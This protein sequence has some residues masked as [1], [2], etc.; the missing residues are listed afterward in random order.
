VAHLDGEQSHAPD[1]GESAL[2]AALTMASRG[3]DE[4]GRAAPGRLAVLYD[5]SCEMCV[6]SIGAIARFDNSNAIDA[7]DLF[8]SKA[9]ERFPDLRRE[10]LVRALHV[11]DDH[12][13]VFRGA[14]ALN[15]ILRHQR[16]PKGWLAYAWFI[17]GFA[18]LA[19]RQYKKI[20]ANRHDR[21]THG[22]LRSA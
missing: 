9:A 6:A 14:R 11:V 15:E 12:G 8:D 1:D 7:L 5:G 13:R 20:A 3:D 10:D 18:W 19:D 21:D 17:P 2:L 22:R 16:G 4:R